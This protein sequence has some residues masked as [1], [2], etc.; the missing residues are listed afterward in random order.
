MTNNRIFKKGN[1][2]VAGALF[3]AIMF[4]LPRIIIAQS[5]L[6]SLH[7][8]ELKSVGVT[9]TCQ[10]GEEI[11]SVTNV[12][13]DDIRRKAGNGS[14]NNIFDLVPSMVTTSDAGTGVGYTYMRIRGIDQTR[15]NV[16]LNGIALNDAESQGSWLVNL[17][18]LG[19]KTQHV[20][21]QRGV[22]TST[23]GAAAF[24]A[25]MN[26]STLEPAE[27]PFLEFNSAAG[28]FYT[29]R[30]TVTASTG[31]I[32]DR[33][34]AAVSYSNIL[35]KG[36][37]DRSSANLNSL[38][39]TADYKMLSKDKTKSYGKLRFN[40]L[41]GKE[42]TGLAWNGVPYDSLST[43]RRYNNCGE[44]YDA[45]GNRHYYEN[46]TDNYN[47]NHF[48]LFYTGYNKPS[49]RDRLRYDIGAHF[50]RGIGY[51]EQFKDDKAFSGYGL[52]NVYH[53]T[54]TI[55]ESDLI[56][57]KYLDNYLYGL[58]FTINQNLNRNKTIDG[59]TKI[60]LWNWTLGGDIKQY[61][62]KHYGTIIWAEHA[63]SILVNTH[64]YDGTGTK[65]QG[66]I[67]A[68]M[69]FSSA[70]IYTY[71]DLQYRL[72]YYN[73]TG[74]NDELVDV[75]QKHLWHFFNPKAGINYSWNDKKKHTHAL[76]LAFAVSHREPTRSDLTDADKE[77]RPKPERLYDI[78]A[79][80]RVTG[81]QFAFNANAYFMYYDNQ[82]VLTGEI[83]N[84]GA[85]LMT[86][87]KKSFRTGVELIARYQ[88]VRWFT[89][90]IN[91]TFSHNK[92]IDYTDFI[93]DWD[94]GGQRRHELGTRTI[95]FSP[96]IVASNDFTF[97]PV[98][99][100]NIS[101]ITKFVSKQYLDNSQDENLIIKPYCVSNL[102]FDYTLHTG[103][104]ADI[105]FFFH[106]NNIFNHKYINNGWRYKWYEG[107][108][109][110]YSS[111]Y[112]PQA[113]INFFGG[114][115]LKFQ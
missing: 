99:D 32:K 80:Y 17:P 3:F 109:I 12:S 69:S 25:T 18:D 5:L 62:G 83:S 11:F 24:G 55:F 71:L 82:L 6:D 74:I 63:D 16:T 56:T 88:P 95:S 52:P 73:I 110:N 87:A 34:S 96:A 97:T 61:D 30:N 41:Y 36:F 15:I 14:V 48:Q 49:A 33:F 45:A 29:F 38:F 90:N 108:E 31:R 107:D 84:T 113:G 105:G 43:N 79:G 64:W 77:N 1:A 44:Y 4:F 86:N 114:I 115:R 81:K 93:D 21:I 10:D 104:I 39:F 94:N 8:I 54:D 40:F 103:A 50:T 65:T 72:I 23:N 92:I 102:Q 28:S 20:E 91:A 9:W 47:Q 101:F 68:T 85:A 51:Y 70:H 19:Q 112:F 2:F 60:R 46:E 59:K 100:F 66:N 27:K 58:T 42:K 13:E 57:R 98:S 35:S 75:G 26:F 53:G 106:I 22:G 111:G 78:E 37:I 89:W 76:Y 7:P 67:F